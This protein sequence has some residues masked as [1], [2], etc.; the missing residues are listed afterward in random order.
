MDQLNSA[1]Q[2]GTPLPS[3][4]EMAAADEAC[5]S[6]GTPSLDLMELAGQA[7]VKAVT[8]E[9]LA[10]SPAVV[11]C[12]PG[13]NGGDGAVI[14]RLLRERGISVSLVLCGDPRSNDLKAKLERFRSSGGSLSSLEVGKTEKLLAEANVIFDCLLGTGQ[15]DAP[16][17]KIK[18]ALET[19]ARIENLNPQAPIVAIDIPTGLNADTGE[20]YTPRVKATLTV[21]IQALKR[22]LTQY[23][24]LD[25][26][27]KVV[28]VDIGI[29]PK[30]TY[31]VVDP[32]E[33]KRILQRPAGAHK[34][35]FGRVLVIGG[36]RSMPGAPVLSAQAALRSGAGLVTMAALHSTTGLVSSWPEIMRAPVD[37]RGLGFFG[38]EA[39][40]F[41]LER[42]N[43][44]DVVILGPG[45]GQAGSTQKLVLELIKSFSAQ[46]KKLVVDADALNALAAQP[47]E[48]YPEV[49]ITPHPGE[50]ARLLKVTSSLVQ[51]DR[52]TAADGLATQFKASVL[53]KGAGTIIRSDRGA[54][55]LPEANPWLATAGSGDVLAGIIGALLA[56]DLNS[57][58][59][60][61][62]G[63][64][65][66]AM[67][68]KATGAA[69]SVPLIASDIVSGI[70]G[71]LALG[72]DIQSC[73]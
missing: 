38:S 72:Q 55:V 4:A 60:A 40:E 66:H 27:G 31:A 51:S 67:A 64:W 21:A 7:A 24:A 48:L 13:N 41:L 54:A 2:F 52:F 11:L 9:G 50:A 47:R 45:M 39:L 37:D 32:S 3:T 36:S 46:R 58:D 8:E 57:F 70:P 34:G 30:S 17:G 22:G 10:I 63:A 43:Q 42:A 59:A 53:L 44:A 56:Q 5:I 19:L 62:C 28:V 73:S 20:V 26:L 18:D 6:S 65:L 16:R 23:P 12:G 14:A 61:Q 35:D 29:L 69:R 1:F 25:F 15:L 71:A 33:L 49:V 68:A